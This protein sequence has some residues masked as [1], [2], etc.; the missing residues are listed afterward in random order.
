MAAP[1]WMTGGSLHSM[2]MGARTDTGQA[3]GLLFAKAPGARISAATATAPG[4]QVAARCRNGAGWRTG[5]RSPPI[6]VNLAVVASPASG[7]GET[8]R[9]AGLANPTIWVP[10]GARVQIGL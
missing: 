10:S 2:A 7:P 5:A 8:F 1:G 4:N 3:M 6:A 9:V